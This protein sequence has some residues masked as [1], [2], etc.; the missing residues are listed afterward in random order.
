MIYNYNKLTPFKKYIIQNF[1]YIDADF[2]SINNYTL[3]CKIVD[4]LNK[5][6]ESNN[7]QDDQIDALTNAFNDLHDYVQDY[8]D[9]LD[10]QDEINNKLDNMVLSGE[11]ET[12]LSSVASSLLTGKIDKDG[13][14]QVT[15]QNLSQGVRELLTGG[16]TA[17]VG[18]E[19]VGSYNMQPDTM[20]YSDLTENAK[21]NVASLPNYSRK[22]LLFE[23]GRR[24]L[25]N[26]LT[27]DATVTNCVTSTTTF[28]LGYCKYAIKIKS[29]FTAYIIGIYNGTRKYITGWSGFTDNNNEL[30]GL[31]CSNQNII[32]NELADFYIEIRKSDQSACTPTEVIDAYELY[33][34][35]EQ[36]IEKIEYNSFDN[37]LQKFLYEDETTVH[38]YGDIILANL[39]L[40]LANTPFRFYDKKFT[41][42]SVNRGYVTTPLYLPAGTVITTTN[43]WQFVILK[44]STRD[45]GSKVYFPSSFTNSHT[46]ATSDNYYICIRKSDNSNFYE[47]ID[48]FAENCTITFP[49]KRATSRE[50][51]YVAP[52]GNDTTGDGTKANP[53]RQISKALSSGGKTISV[54]VGTYDPFSIVGDDVKIIGEIETYNSSSNPIEQRA[55]ITNGISLTVADASGLLES[56]YT[57]D[58]DS[59]MYKCLVAK[60]K[61]LHD[62]TSERSYG[63]YATI[64]SKGNKDTSHRYIPT[65]SDTEVEST[66]GTFYYDGT[67][68]TIHPYTDNDETFEYYLVDSDSITN[69]NLCSISSA[70]N[71]VLENLS[72]EFS[73]NDLLDISKA[74]NVVINNCVFVG[75]SIEN[76]VAFVD[77]NG[78]ITNCV[79][80]LARND[81][82]NFHGFGSTSIINSIGCNCFDDGISHHDDCNSIITGG[83]YYGNN[84]GGVST[85][86]YGAKST[87]DSV[88][89]HDNGY[90]IY[91]VS[92][93]SHPDSTIYLSNCLIASNNVGIN[94]SSANGCIYNNVLHGNT[95]NTTGTNNCVVYNNTSV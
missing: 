53:Y 77:G 45:V 94:V 86:T 19:T 47:D 24:D 34:Y 43:D 37:S 28:K 65:L 38:P 89:T 56:T 91:C 84:K 22:Y 64:Y 3:Y 2:D 36:E 6:I 81:G 66:Q 4:Y 9:N 25:N 48:D 72:F 61:D 30:F 69:G 44:K 13:V 80:Y 78:T 15:V 5:V 50:T 76:N 29:G 74:S 54:E 73:N 85:P 63:Y 75:S 71:I 10:V 55:T 41:D 12:L 20:Q 21:K 23:Q 33:E 82:Y 70:N 46:V 60:T 88:Y 68:I 18:Y 67:T 58:T 59:S 57:A 7:N 11:F 32:Y 93:A 35:N 90:G 87:I 40:G 39:G 16:S 27:L 79:S 14:G 17:V 42:S 49:S 26:D 31:Q 51:F 1:P 8:F 95:T 83:E 52:S 62:S 92:D